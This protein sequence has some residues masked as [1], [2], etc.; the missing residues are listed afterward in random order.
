[1]AVSKVVPGTKTALACPSLPTLPAATYCVSSN[2]DSSANQPFEVMVEVSVAVSSAPSTSTGMQVAVFAQASYDGGTTWQ[3]GP[4][5]GTDATNEPDMTF[6]G[7]VPVKSSGNTPPHVR[8]F[9]VGLCF[10]GVLPPLFRVV[11]KNDT[12][13]ALTQ[14]TVATIEFTQLSV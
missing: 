9:P 11:L 12:G 6:L 1:M 2:K 5:S 7:V 10:G 4:T 13:V 3:S 8:S 14:G